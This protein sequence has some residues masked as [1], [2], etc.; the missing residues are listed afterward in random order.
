IAITPV[1]ANDPVGAGEESV[2]IKFFDADAL[3]ASEQRCRDLREYRVVDLEYVVD[4]TLISATPNTASITLE[5]TNGAGAD[6]T[7]NTTGQTVVSNNLADADGLNRYDVYGV[8][9]CVDIALANS[10]PVTFTVYAVA[11]K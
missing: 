7:V 8:Y 3:T 2:L 9:T 5:H 1:A 10:Q 6:L 11:R 4:Q